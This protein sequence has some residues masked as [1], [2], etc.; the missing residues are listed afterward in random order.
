MGTLAG[1]LRLS[2]STSTASSSSTTEETAQQQLKT[3]PVWA[4]MQQL[5]QWSDVGHIPSDAE[6]AALG[7]KLPAFLAKR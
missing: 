5:A 3:N 6:L 1:I 4:A 7:V 2:E